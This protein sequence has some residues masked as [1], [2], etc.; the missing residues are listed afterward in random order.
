MER[1]YGGREQG[2]DPS[3]RAID[4][5]VGDELVAFLCPALAGERH[6]GYSAAEGGDR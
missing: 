4:K 6:G 5:V 2:A 3:R 1:F